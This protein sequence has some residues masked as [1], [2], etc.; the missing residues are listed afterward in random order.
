MKGSKIWL[1][2][3]EADRRRISESVLSGFSCVSRNGFSKR[4]NRPVI[5]LTC[6]LKTKGSKI[7]H[8][9]WG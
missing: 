7:R 3:W 6:V 1:T 9:I 8:T 5:K 2:K 4:N